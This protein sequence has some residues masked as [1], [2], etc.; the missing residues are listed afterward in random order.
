MGSTGPQRRCWRSAGPRALR[1]RVIFPFSFKYFPFV[2]VLMRSDTQPRHTKLQYDHVGDPLFVHFD[3]VRQIEA[4][5]EGFTWGRAR[6]VDVST[7][8]DVEADM[9]ANVLADGSGII[10]STDQVKRRAAA[11]RYLRA[12]Y[13][14]G[15]PPSSSKSRLPTMVLI[16]K[17]SGMVRP[18]RRIDRRS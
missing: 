14:A 11:E 12:N 4:I 17:S 10:A 13:H 18:V 2:H 9:L 15:A 5:R 3:V 8:D 16:L 7:T 6:V 1:V